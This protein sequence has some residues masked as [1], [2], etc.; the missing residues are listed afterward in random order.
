MNPDFIQVKN[1]L[2]QKYRDYCREDFIP[3]D[4]VSIPHLFDR[5]E[6]IEIAGLLTATIS[7]GQRGTILQNARQLMNFMDYSPYEFIMGS[8]EIDFKELKT[9]RHRTFNGTDCLFFINSI[10][11]IYLH[12]GGLEEV[13]RSGNNE[14]IKASIVNFRNTFLSIPYPLRTAKHVADPSAGASA[15]RLNMF[16]RWMVRKED[17]GVDFGLWKSVS[18]ANLYCPL[19]IHTG[20]VARKLGLISRKQNDWKALEEL[21]VHLRAFD[22]EDP[23]KY[24]FALFGLGIF[25]KF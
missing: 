15:K 3:G 13:F 5:K 6:D 21:M 22:P 8:E 19:D 17:E 4:P 25:E 12:H 16:L 7:W 11:N 18:P 2:D 9:F 14:D 1:L 23:V 20:N 24:D 10:R